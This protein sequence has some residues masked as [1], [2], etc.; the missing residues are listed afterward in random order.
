MRAVVLSGGGG[1]GAYQ[2]GVWKALRKL[3]IDY[4][5]VTGTSVGALNGA[6]MVQGDYFSALWMWYHINFDTITGQKVI[7]NY[8]TFDGWKSILKLYGKGVL[9]G[10]LDVSKLEDT[11]Q[12]SIRLNKFYNSKIKYGLVTVNFSTF[13]PVE[14]KKNQI[15]RDQLKDY[16]M[17]SATCFPAFKAKKIGDA[18]YVDGGYYDNL[19]INLAIELGADEII[20]VDLK[21]VGVKKKAKEEIPITY[22]SPRADIGSFLVFDREISKRAIRL[23][24]LDTM[25]AYFKLEGDTITFKKG[26]LKR[27]ERKYK[28]KVIAR[29]ELLLSGKK[30]GL[31]KELLAI[32]KYHAFLKNTKRV[33][34]E[35][36]DILEYLGR[37]F[38]LSDTKIYSLFSFERELMRKFEKLAPFEFSQLEKKI[39]TKKLKDIR[40]S[41]TVVQYLVQKIEQQQE[42][43]RPEFTMLA[44]LFPKDML[45][46]IYI[47]LLS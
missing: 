5:I 24:Y 7:G 47:T 30:R 23:G 33:E 32:P 16:L 44:L 9:D 27:N 3:N 29:L 17:A 39:V 8:K 2:I 19:P 14:L 37:A 26:E 12:K 45:A 1:K 31:G 18:T 46:A 43:E 28:E 38:E 21:S 34:R 11:I 4:Q 36:E 22:I 6:F 25:K 15:P 13:K 20:A 42:K 41:K 40:Y 35:M 10:G